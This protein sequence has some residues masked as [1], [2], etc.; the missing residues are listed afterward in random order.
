MAPS[1]QYRKRSEHDVTYNSQPM[2]CCTDQVCLLSRVAVHFVCRIFQLVCSKLLKL[3]SI[4]QHTKSNEEIEIYYKKWLEF[5]KLN[6]FLGQKLESN[7]YERLREFNVT[8]AQGSAF[9]IDIVTNTAMRWSALRAQGETTVRHKLQSDP[10]R[11]SS[12]GRPA[13]YHLCKHCCP[14]MMAGWKR[15][16]NVTFL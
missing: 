3:C 1:T 8:L 5:G 6:T 9:R 2:I 14:Q 13:R 12:I 11:H 7:S 10:T 4:L 15:E 16:F